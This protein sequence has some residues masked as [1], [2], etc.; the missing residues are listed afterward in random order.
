MA[1][2]PDGN[3]YWMVASDGG[4]F[5][6]GDAGFYGSAGGGGHP[7]LTGSAVALEPT[8]DGRG[9]LLVTDRGNTLPFGDAT[10]LS[11]SAPLPSA[12]VVSAASL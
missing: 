7:P 6:F 10:A 2:T 4:V 3:G 8:P 12:P 1:A 11:P 9:Y 5:T